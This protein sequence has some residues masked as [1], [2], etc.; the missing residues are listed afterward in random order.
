MGSNIENL[1][2]HI[3]WSTKYRY[4]L[5]TIEM[6][7][8]LKQYFLNKQ[9]QW[10]YEAKSIAI[11]PEHIHLLIQ[12]KSSHVYLNRLIA[13]LKGGSSF[14]LRKRFKFL[15]SYPSLWT[16]SHFVASVGNVS[17]KVIEEYLNRQGIEE[18]EIVARTFKYKVLQPSKSKVRLLKQYFKA[19][20]KKDKKKVPSAILQD[21]ERIKRKEGEFGLY[22]RGQLLELKESDTKEAKYWLRISGSK[23]EKPFWL[24]LRG[25]DLPLDYKLRD[26]TIREKDGTYFVCL[27]I[28]QER[29]IKRAPQDKVIAVD[30]GVNHPITSVE[31]NDSKM[32]NNK[33]YGKEAKNQIYRRSKRHA[34]LQSSGIK[35]PKEKTKHYTNRI[36]EFVHSYTN[37]VVEKAK[38]TN[39][40]IVVGNLRGI[41]DIWTKGK[42]N[43]TTRRKANRVPYGRIMSQLWY[44]G[45][46]TGVPVVFVNEAYT[47]QRCSLC[48]SVNHL[49]RVGEVFKCRSCGYSNQADLN[50]AINIGTVALANLL[51]QGHQ[52]L[53]QET[54]N[55]SLSALAIGR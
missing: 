6:T 26:S 14:L 47:S 21:F 49:N 39:S 7:E 32:K 48:G 20:L 41:K 22:L 16:P 3:V 23:Y 38:E 12:I 31:L 29:I 13:K 37:K 40:S 11:E 43:K 1:Q 17:D 4:R 55:T 44:K 45:T 18:K 35:E 51:S 8:I 52:A 33:F 42:T 10:K 54:A 36:K 28:E 5:L 2:Y 50:G 15:N 25:R 53:K 24:G 34:Q 46:L 19:C 9:E 30:L 27:S